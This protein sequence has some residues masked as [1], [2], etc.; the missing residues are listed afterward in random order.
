[1][2]AL[3][4]EIKQIMKLYFLL[5]NGKNKMLADLDMG[6]F[7]IKNVFELLC[8]EVIAVADVTVGGLLI[9]ESD[10]VFWGD[11][12]FL[13]SVSLNDDLDLG[14]FGVYD[15]SLIRMLDVG[16]IFTQPGVAKYY[17]LQSH[18]GANYQDCIKLI[19]GEAQILRSG[20]ITGLAGKTVDFPNVDA[21][22]FKVSGANGVDGSFTTVDGKTVTVSKGLIT[23]IV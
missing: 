2:E 11:T 12:E 16:R 22:Q 7:S 6:G 19:G 18:D 3:I 4:P 14:G 1:M 20:N 10:S 17:T 23:N 15:T 8:D 21:D 9:A 13:G 5:L